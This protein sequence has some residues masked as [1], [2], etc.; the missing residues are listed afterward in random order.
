MNDCIQ[1]G[2]DLLTNKGGIYQACKDY[3]S[4]LDGRILSITDPQQSLDGKDASVA[5][6]MTGKNPMSRLS[7]Y[8]PHQERTRFYQCLAEGHSALFL[9]GC[10]RLSAHYVM[11]AS[12]QKGTPYVFVPHGGLD[13]WVFTYRR[14]VKLMWMR[15]YG[16]RILRNA[17][18]VLAMTRNEMAKIQR[19]VGVL[20]NQRVIYLPLDINGCKYTKDRAVV[21]A[22]RG[23]PLDACVLCYL[24]RLHHMKRP[25]ETIEAVL[26]ASNNIHLVVAGPDDSVTAESLKQYVDKHDARDRIHVTGPIYGDEKYNLLSACDAYISLSHRENFNYTAAEAMAMS[27]PV[28]LSPGN[29]LQGE[30]L[31][32]NCGWML[33]SLDAS[34]VKESLLAFEQTSPDDLLRKGSNGKQWVLDH[35]TFEH[36]QS[37]LQ[38]LVGSL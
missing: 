36:F 31:D 28:I 5:Y 11:T 25:Q 17:D 38:E 12:K 20:P 1:V 3:Y 23:I 37:Q 29:D 35:L 9:H 6:F 15:M 16:L 10:Y 27:L 26:A 13:P 4:A 22:E 14:A 33:D 18:T 34:T 7:G 21:R 32:A 2:S 19:F 8:M 30:I 24:G